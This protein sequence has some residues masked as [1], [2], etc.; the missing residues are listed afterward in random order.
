MIFFSVDWGTTNCR[1]KLVKISQG[2]VTLL[3]SEQ[4]AMGVSEVYNGWLERP[5]TDRADYYLTRLR[6]YL[7]K[8]TADL[9]LPMQT[10]QET[11]IVISGMASS[12]IGIEEVPYSMV[13][14]ELDPPKINLKIMEAFGN[15][16][17]ILFSGLRTEGNIM[18][19]EETQ[20]IGCWQQTFASE[21]KTFIFPGTHSK[22]IDVAH[23]T[24]RD[25]R[26]FITGE[27]LSLLTNFST[28]KT[29]VSATTPA[30]I[31][32]DCFNT[33]L[34]TG[35]KTD[36]LEN[37]FT[38]RCN[39]VLN[40]LTKSQNYDFLIGLLLGHELKYLSG[41]DEIVLCA[42]IHLA[43]VYNLALELLGLANHTTMVPPDVVE[44]SAILGQYK[45]LEQLNS[46][47]LQQSE[48]N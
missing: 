35:K 9:G 38:V 6:P 15:P 42:G 23:A 26:T 12:S 20:L 31:D 5:R 2:R 34:S 3:G 18:R 41:G 44:Q 47:H 27:L 39:E 29:N 19:G 32:V 25:F 36:L 17:V 4:A 33:G 48:K 1:I 28:I 22:H 37:I 21:R 10:L 43:P 14:F 7:E 46:P 30:D 40:K 24:V 45:I 11:P 8:I 16:Q 13:P